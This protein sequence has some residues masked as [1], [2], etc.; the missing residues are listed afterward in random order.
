MKQR[1][2]ERVT[3][4]RNAS[5]RLASWMSLVAVVLVMI[6]SVFRL[7]SEPFH[8]G[9]AA[10]VTAGTALA[11]FHIVRLARLKRTPQARR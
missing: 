6:P 8:W 3:E 7:I 1:E 2:Q 5:I 10:M 9:D 11:A 4:D